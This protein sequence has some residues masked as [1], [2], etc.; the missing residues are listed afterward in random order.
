MDKN[1]SARSFAS[2]D[3]EQYDSPMK[4]TVNAFFQ[5]KMI[6][7]IILGFIYFTITDSGREFSPQVNGVLHKAIHR[8]GE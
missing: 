2:H 3:S 8:K 1:N 4:S 5:K 6:I 7:N